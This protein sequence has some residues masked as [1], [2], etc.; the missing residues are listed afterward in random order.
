MGTASLAGE[1][2]APR[3]DLAGFERVVRPFLAKYCGACH[4]PKKQEAGLS[5]AALQPNLLSGG[6]AERW[7]EVLSRLNLGDMPPQKETQPQAS[8]VTA[9][10]D[11]LTR[12]LN[13]ARQVAVAQGGGRVL[14][15]LTNA[16]YRNTLASLIDLPYSPAAHFPHDP[17]TFGFDNVGSGLT[18]SPLHIE[19][20]LDAAERVLDLALVEGAAPEKVHWRIDYFG[21]VGG[22]LQRDPRGDSKG[23]IAGNDSAVKP[24]RFRGKNDLFDYRGD[25]K[26]K[27]LETVGP[28]P[29]LHADFTD[30]T[31]DPPTV[32]RRAADLF[33]GGETAYKN[34]AAGQSVVRLRLFNYD[35]G[36]YRLRIK[37]HGFV[38]D[39]WQG[40]LPSL[41]VRLE[42]EKQTVRAVELSSE[43]Q[44]IEFS[45]YRESIAAYKA[46]YN[47]RSF[48]VSLLFPSYRLTPAR[49]GGKRE[50]AAIGVHVE[51]IELEGPYL[52]GWPPPSHRQI[53]FDS[54]LATTDESAYTREVLRRFIARAYRRPATEADLAAMLTLFEARRRGGGNYLESLKTPL[55]AVLASPKFLC[56]VEPRRPSEA[57]RPLDG[58]ELAARLSYFL[59]SGPPDDELL[60]AAAAGRLTRDESLLSHTVRLLADSRARQFVENFVDQWL[61]LRKLETFAPDATLYPQFDD[62]LRRAMLRETQACFAEVLR[63]NSS[64]LEFLDSDWTMLNQ[65]LA[66]HYGIRGVVG[67]EFRRVTLAPEHH[68]GGLLTHASVL[69]VT[70]NGIRTLPVQR[71]VFVLDHLLAD[72]PPP[73]PPNAGQLEET[74]P[75]AEHLSV[76][77][78]LEQ[79]R[80]HTACAACHAKIDPYG[81]AMESYD[82]IGGWRTHERLLVD[83]PRKNKDG[84]ID[85]VPQAVVGEAV[86]TSAQLPDGRAYGGMREFQQLLLT[87]P[88]RQQFVKALTKKLLTYALGRGLT[89]ADDRLVESLGKKCAADGYR[90]RS[91]IEQIVLSEEFRTK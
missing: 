70:S 22:I 86:E 36:T 77:E 50:R 82:A 37:A 52:A 76:K 29:E 23:R 80:R 57:P 65:T 40:T 43:P 35:P 25:I 49:P 20:Y 54:P 28:P 46:R 1:A 18:F 73:P 90:L 85:M 13:Q 61:Q 19:N 67:P 47:Q 34:D 59:W 15:R 7:N 63:D 45:I 16:E 79:H 72:P 31:T 58:Y 24:G 12:E 10:V 81:F 71:G 4:G 55:T 75:E 51:S 21:P 62:A 87:E 44:T 38:P 60:A 88:L 42:P 9:V 64:V 84:S 39:D 41:E 78:R 17:V 14:R 68:R 56:I 27:E 26:Y 11:W 48:G 91:L 30:L 3:A 74:A 2:T 5:L 83:A 53:L 8:E 66:V 32:Y 33:L 89:F 6:D 69:T